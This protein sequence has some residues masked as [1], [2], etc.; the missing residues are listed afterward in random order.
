MRARIAELR[1]RVQLNMGQVVLA[2]MNLPRYRNQ[3]LGDLTHL[4][5]DPMMR[6]RVAVAHRTVEGKPQGDEDVAGIAIWATVSDAVDAKIAEQI[7]AGAFPVRLGPDDWTSGDHVWLF[8]VIAAD[9]KQATSVLT[10]FRL[11]AG[12]RPVRIAPLVGR[13][14]DPDV[15]E[16]LKGAVKARA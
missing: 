5:L 2:M 12:E 7:K 8:D 14:I 15:L 10:N 3:T 11:L 9:R 4:V 16:K 6:D 1:N 13:L